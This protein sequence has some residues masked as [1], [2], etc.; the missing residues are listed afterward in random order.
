MN[1]EQYVNYF[2]NMV[3]D[4]AKL[5]HTHL[6]LVQECDKN[7]IKDSIIEIEGIFETIAEEL[8]RKRPRKDVV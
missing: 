5:C 2:L 3:K 8:S 4:T 1:D 7:K 6:K